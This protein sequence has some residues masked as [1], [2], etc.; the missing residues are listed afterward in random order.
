MVSAGAQTPAV[1]DDAEPDPIP[2]SSSIL[3]YV[4]GGVTL[5]GGVGAAIFWL[6]AKRARADANARYPSDPAYAKDRSRFKVERGLGYAFSGVAALGLGLALYGW[7]KS[8]E[9]EHTA[10]HR[11]QLGIDPADGGAVITLGG[12]M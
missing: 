9:P 7:L 3:P 1:G 8:D 12:A 4:G 11:P 6:D 10:R 2:A 5:I